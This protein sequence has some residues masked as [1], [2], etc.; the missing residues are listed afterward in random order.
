MG[1]R[2]CGFCVLG[3]LTAQKGRG[4]I[5]ES[6][7]E[8]C[9]RYYNKVDNHLIT[10]LVERWGPET[11]TFHFPFGEATITL[12]DV[13]ILWGLP[14]SDPV[15][16][17]GDGRLQLLLCYGLGGSFEVCFHV[18]RLGKRRFMWVFLFY[19]PSLD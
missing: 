13:H 6:G 12:E 9:I 5:I 4:W 14:L 11:H 15:L 18:M 16:S 8:A 2:S 10:S 1:F 17:V 19:N 3:V 7:S